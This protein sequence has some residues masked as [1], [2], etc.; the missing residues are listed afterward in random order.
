MLCSILTALL[1]SMFCFKTASSPFLSIVS[2]TLPLESELIGGI[3]ANATFTHS[4]VW[5]PFYKDRSKI[6]AG[7]D[8]VKRGHCLQSDF[9]FHAAD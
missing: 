7:A 6:C 8:D 4:V 1:Q 5:Q 3:H 2:R 9:Y